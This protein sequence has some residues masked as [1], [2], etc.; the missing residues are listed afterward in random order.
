MAQINK[1]L[2]Q[3][4]TYPPY[5]GPGHNPTSG[6]DAT[7][8]LENTISV[9]FGILSVVAFIYFTIQTIFAGYAFISSQGDTKKLEEARHKLTNGILGLTIIV[10]A[11]GLGSLLAAIFGIESI[12]NLD[13]LLNN[14]HL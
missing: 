1:L 9:V 3:V 11:V 10:V 7:T 5:D 13:Q 8:N 2:A 4:V 6:A 14:L 12:M